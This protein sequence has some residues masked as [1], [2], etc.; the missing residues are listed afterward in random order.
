[1]PPLPRS[2]IDRD[3][4]RKA[5]ARL[6]AAV[7]VITS[8]GPAGLGGTTV[9]AVCS[10]TDSPATLLVCI[11]RAARSNAVICGNGVFAVNVLAAGHEAVADRFAR[12]DLDAGA[13]LAKTPHRRL[14]TGAPVLDA[15]LIAFDCEVAQKIEAGTHTI[16]LG[17]VVGL[18]EGAHPGALIYLA[19]RYIG[20]GLETGA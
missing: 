8:D 3:P 18:R 11:N 16:F 17:R 2:A 9:S 19:R 5:M 4:F 15:A 20:I 1:M 6:G 7:S 10:V 14:G 13:R 12:A